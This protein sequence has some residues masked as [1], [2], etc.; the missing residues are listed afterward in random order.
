LDYKQTA[1]RWQWALGNK[2]ANTREQLA[3]IRHQQAEV[4]KA[5]GAL[6]SWHL[7]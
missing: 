2:K 4:S 1:G 3:Q 6:P 7:R 5:H